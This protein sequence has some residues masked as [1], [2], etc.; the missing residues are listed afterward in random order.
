MDWPTDKPIDYARFEICH[1]VIR[2]PIDRPT[3][4]GDFYGPHQGKS[5]VPIIQLYY[6]YVEMNE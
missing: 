5:W 3:D 2:K 6:N 1:T 4:K